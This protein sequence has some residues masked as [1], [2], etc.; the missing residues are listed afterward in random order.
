VT[1][2]Y[3]THLIQE[4]ALSLDPQTQS[5]LMMAGFRREVAENCPLQG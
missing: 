2:K 5:L 1:K 3:F 4:T